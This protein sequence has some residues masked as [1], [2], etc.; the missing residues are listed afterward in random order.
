MTTHPALTATP[1]ILWRWTNRTPNASAQARTALRCALD[2]LGYDGDAIGDALLAVSELVDN[3]IE[4]AVG[5]YEMRLLRT[6][7]AVI[8]EVEDHDPCIPKIPELP[9]EPPF[10][11]AEEDRGGG[12][13]ALC[14]LLSERGRGFRIVHELTQGVWGF[15]Q[16]ERA[17]KTA[18]LAIPTASWPHAEPVEQV[19]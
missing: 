13:E 3:A 11:P 8:C 2:Q 10:A 18:W 17:T 6:S 14:A 7:A 15:T 16:G 4:H 9:A 19:A 12:L 5:P 1:S